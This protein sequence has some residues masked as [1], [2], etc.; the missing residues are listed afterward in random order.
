MNEAGGFLPEAD[1][2]LD[3][4]ERREMA[5]RSDQRAQHAKLRAIVAI[6]RVEGIA[7]KTAVA[8]AARFPAAPDTDLCLELRRSGADQRNLQPHRRIAD[9]QPGSEVVAAVDDQRMAGKQ[10]LGIVMIDPGLDG[11]GL[12][13]RIQSLDECGRGRRFRHP[14]LVGAEDRLALEVGQIEG[15]VVDDCQ[16]PKTR[17]GE[18]RYYGTA[19]AAGTDNDGAGRL[20]ACLTGAADV[21]QDNVPG[22]ALKLV[23]RKIHWPVE[24]KPPLPRAVSSSACTSV[25]W[26]R[27]TGAGTSWAMR[28]PRRTGNGSVPRL[29]RMTFTSP[30]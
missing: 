20:E 14:D 11:R 18:C 12:H 9:C 21:G 19:D 27:S 6:V 17:A 24:P 15:I 8:R 28:S 7:D 1:D 3:C 30:R 10:V 4:H 13:M 5:S 22:V 23:V 2:V 16:S 26:A 25:N 29:M